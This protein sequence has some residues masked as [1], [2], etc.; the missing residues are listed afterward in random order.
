MCFHKCSLSSVLITVS[1][2]Y[3]AET[4]HCIVVTGTVFNNATVSNGFRVGSLLF[5]L[6]AVAATERRSRVLK[7]TRSRDTR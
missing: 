4:R 3:A 2:L 5:Y 1:L 7:Y 6:L